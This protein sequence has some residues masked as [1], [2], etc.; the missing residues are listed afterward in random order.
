MIFGA[1]PVRSHNVQQGM[2]RVIP[3]NRMGETVKLIFSSETKSI[4][5]SI[6]H[7]DGKVTPI[8]QGDIPKEFSLVKN[9]DA[10]RS[11]FSCAYAVINRMTEGDYSLRIGQRIVGGAPTPA[12]Q[13][14]AL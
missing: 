9:I 10:F 12:E 13:T 4:S 8:K 1:L 7:A 3:T 14:T 11:F 5:A 2:E 6:W